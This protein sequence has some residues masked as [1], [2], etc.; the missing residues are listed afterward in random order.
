MFPSFCLFFTI[1]KCSIVSPHLCKSSLKNVTQFHHIRIIYFPVHSH[2]SEFILI[3]KGIFVSLLSKVYA[4]K[5]HAFLHF[6]KQVN[7]NHVHF[8]YA[9]GR[10]KSPKGPNYPI[11]PWQTSKLKFQYLWRQMSCTYNNVSKDDVT[12]SLMPRTL[13]CLQHISSRYYT[14]NL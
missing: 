3:N 13:F 10:P 2:T 14:W 7:I 5:S 8:C 4:V 9:T 6:K 12:N 11:F 1:I